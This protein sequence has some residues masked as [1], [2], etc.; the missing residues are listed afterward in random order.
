MRYINQQEIGRGAWGVV[1]RAEDTVTGRIVALKVLPAGSGIPKTELAL[2]QVITHLYVCRVYDYFQ[3]PDG[4]NCITMEYVDGGSLRRLIESSPD[5]IGL[6][7]SIA[8]AR[9]VL[10]ALEALHSHGI[11]HRDL[12]PENILLTSG[13]MIKVSDFGLARYIGEP[14]SFESR[15]EIG[16]GTPLYMAPEQR[17]GRYDERSDIYSFGV[18]LSELLAGKPYKAHTILELPG[19]LPASVRSALEAC[20]QFDPGRRLASVAAV[21]E[22]LQLSPASPQQSRHPWW[23]TAALGAAAVV[24]LAGSVHMWND[25]RRQ[26]AAPPPAARLDPGLVKVEPLL[27]PSGSTA[28]HSIAVLDFEN[29]TGDKSL[30]PYTVGIA[31]TLGT[32]LAQVRGLTVVDRNRVREAGS[33]LHAA[34]TRQTGQLIGA[35]A[36]VTGSFQKLGGK[37][38]LSARVLDTDTGAII[39]APALVDGSFQDLFK[40]QAELAKQLAVVVEN[41]MGRSD[42]KAGDAAEIEIAGH[43]VEAFRAFSDGLYFLRTDLPADALRRFDLALKVEPDYPGAQ[44]YRGVSLAKLHRTDE[45]IEAFKSALPRS[46]QDGLV[47]WKWDAPA[48]TPQHGLVRAMDTSRVHLQFDLFNGQKRAPLERQIIYVER[49]DKST[50]LHFLDPVKRTERQLEVADP[51]IALNGTAYGNEAITVLPAVDRSSTPPRITLYAFSDG[52][53]VL[54]HTDLAIAGTDVPR[55]AVV[56]DVFYI[57]YAGA[58]RFDLLDV[59]T[60]NLLWR[61][62]GLRVDPAEAPMLRHTKANGDLLIVKSPDMY[63]AIRKSDGREVWT[64]PVQSAKTSELA[65]DRT[66]IVFEPERRIF[67]VDFETGKTTGEVQ[68]RQFADNLRTEFGPKTLVGAVLDGNTVYFLSDDLQVCAF[69]VGSGKL[70]WRTAFGKKIQGMRAGA[71]HLYL[72]TEAGE[73]VALDSKSGAITDTTKLTDAPVLLEYAGGDGVV[74]RSANRL[75][76]F[77]IAGEKRWEYPH[78]EPV[79]VDYFQGAVLMYTAPLQLSALE[80]GTGKILW[81]YSSEQAPPPYMYVTGDR[82]FVLDTNGAREYAGRQR[83]SGITEKETLT[84]L[85]RAYIQKKDLSSARVFLEKAAEVD[86]N[87][88]GVVLVRARLLQAEGRKA[89]A[90]QSLARYASL[91]GFESKEGQRTIAEMKRDYGLL[92]E[93]AIGQSVTGEPAVIGDRLVSVGRKVATELTI[94]GLDAANGVAVWRYR[95]ER[96]A[97]STAANA[98]VWYVSGSGVDATSVALYRVDPKT[99]ERRQIAAWKRGPRIDQAWI[100]ADGTRVFVGTVAADMIAGKVDLVVDAFDGA[101]GAK[102][103]EKIQSVKAVGRELGDPVK[104]FS[105]DKDVVTYAMAGQSWSVRAADGSAVAAAAKTPVSN[106]VAMPGFSLWLP[107]AFTVQNGRLYAFTADG[108]AYAMGAN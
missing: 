46:G 93:T 57:Y 54:W 64:V 28:V 78:V 31:E 41:A 22:A 15:M 40:L 39:R 107:S 32:E 14:V 104:V 106:K 67:T 7:Q 21:R 36:L 13:G 65:N 70:L 59:R 37:V 82:L 48:T 90:G 69:S 72:G 56:G 102:V 42:R 66:L 35:D 53:S 63:G 76:G 5:G 103:W 77:G 16:A 79:E 58:M 61:R 83:G 26:P 73:L 25:L 6:E 91:A 50:M 94:A 68:I 9:Q 24:I 45:A 23:R 71:G 33:Q 30:D 85:A 2:G 80:V 49:I 1:Y 11:V 27:P 29:L 20:L 19:D 34:D 47:S 81:Q 87:D 89:Q 12:K 108:R 97:A 84:E 52:T 44:H 18:I 51:N 96:F 43:S 88:P 60:G 17:D 75:F 86:T 105:V 101:S 55:F 4:T 100:A 99:G 98:C 8:I 10:D 74:A 62:D 92:W 38:R 95:A 3:Q